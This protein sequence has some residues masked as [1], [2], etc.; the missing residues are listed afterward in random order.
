MI[1]KIFKTINNK[2]SKL[3]KFIF[4]IRYLF[5]IFFVAIVSFFI[6]PNFF[7]Y[8]KKEQTVKTSLLQNYGIEIRELESI[9][10]NSFPSP[11]LKI[12]NAIVNFSS[13]ETN[14]KIQELIIFPKIFDIYNYKNFNIRK[15]QLENTDLELD[16]KNLKIF[17]KN[18]LKFEKKVFFKNLNL[19]VKDG[20]KN[21]INLKNINYSNYGY[22]KNI[23][24]GEIFKRKFEINLKDKLKNFNFKLLGTGIYASLNISEYIS[25]KKFTGRLKGKILKSNF[26]IDFVFDADEI[27]VKEFIFRDKKLSF[28]S[29]GKIV[30]KPFFL[31]DVNSNIKN[32]DNGFLKSLNIEDLINKKNLIKKLN[33]KNK[34]YFRS[35][36][37]GKNLIDNLTLE[38][39]LSYGRLNIIK[40]FSIS[41]SNFNC[42]NN[43]NLIEE[44]PIVYFNCS[45]YSLDKKKLLNKIGIKTKIKNEILD[46]NIKGNL[47]LLNQ[48][49]NFD[50]IEINKDSK[51]F[52]NDLKYY[53]ISFENILFN[54]NFLKIF[55]LKKI[56]K[57]ILEIS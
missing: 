13:K 2:F 21:F 39:D 50:L 33:V 22:N 45:I 25:E 53:K 43:T 29:S 47:N 3:F 52:E 17:S 11:N 32:I 42:N 15:I 24:E 4:F 6:I 10:F 27:K 20:K 57:F 12:K 55:D 38:T 23:I 30:L 49:I 46:I 7:D 34:I 35:K 56:R 5:A 37:F 31:I 16:L 19:N 48:K 41:N 26:K 51:T 1:N 8:S 18:I 14:L 44:Y 54:E 40:K 36:K 9:N 28:N